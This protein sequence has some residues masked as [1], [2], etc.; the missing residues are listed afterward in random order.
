LVL[1]GPPDAIIGLFAK[2]INVDEAKASGLAVTGDPR[3]LR[4]LRPPGR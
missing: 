1:T 2:R 4:K 3:Q